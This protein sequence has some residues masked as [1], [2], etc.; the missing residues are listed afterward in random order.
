MLGMERTTLTRNLRP[1]L[2]RGYVSEKPSDDRRVRTVALTRS[3]TEA[4]AGA[5]PYWRKA[6]REFEARLGAGAVRAL[7]VLAGPERSEGTRLYNNKRGQS[8]D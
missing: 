4:M 3:G 5:L 8:P 6:Q 2:T 1:L 7:G